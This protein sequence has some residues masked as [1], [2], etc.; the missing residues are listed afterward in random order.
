M[1]TSKMNSIGYSQSVRKEI[2]AIHEAHLEKGSNRQ[3]LQRQKKEST[4]CRYLLFF[5]K[6]SL[7]NNKASK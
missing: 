3:M 7:K 2:E 1:N 6:L 4:L 5:S